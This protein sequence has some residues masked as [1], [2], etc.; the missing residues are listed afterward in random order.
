M[1][2]IPDRAYAQ[3]REAKAASERLVSL[4]AAKRAGWTQAQTDELSCIYQILKGTH[5]ALN[6]ILETNASLPVK[7]PQAAFPHMREAKAASDRLQSLV[8]TKRAGWTQ[9][10]TDELS[11]IY[12]VLRGTHAALNSMLETN[13]SMSGKIPQAAYSRMQEAKGCIGQ[14]GRTGRHQASGGGHPRKPTT[15]LHLSGAEGDPRCA[16]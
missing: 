12:Q 3:M 16:Q 11:C 8:G 14:A 6:S 7:I 13:A 10:Q 2:K 4:V 5:G 15:F 1:S 9:A